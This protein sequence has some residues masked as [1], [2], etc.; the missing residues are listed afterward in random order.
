MRF[1]LYCC[2]AALALVTAKP[3]PGALVNELSDTTK[4]LATRFLDPRADLAPTA[5]T[6]CANSAI[7]QEA[8]ANDLAVGN[9]STNNRAVYYLAADWQRLENSSRS[10]YSDGLLS[11][12]TFSTLLQKGF[13]NYPTD[14]NQAQALTLQ[15][16]SYFYG[17]K[18]VK[19]TDV[20][21][22]IVEIS[23][24][25][26]Q[27][28]K[29]FGISG[30]WW[31]NDLNFFP[32][33]SQKNL[34]TLLFDKDWLYVSGYRYNVG[35]SGDHD[36][37][38]SLTYPSPL[39]LV[40]S[41]MKT[42]GTYD[43]T[44]D[45]PGIYYL[46]AAQAANVPS[47]AFFLNAQP[48][49]LTQYKQA[50]G[51]TLDSASIPAYVTFIEQVLAHWAEEGIRIEYISPINEPDDN[52]QKGSS[53][54]WS[55]PQEGMQVP[56]D[57][58][59]AVFQQLRAA[60]AA[61]S[62][63]GAK[64]VKIM[65]DEASQ[66]TQQALVEYIH[67]Y[68]GLLKSTTNPGWLVNTL[69]G[70]YIDAIAVHM[71]D[72]P[73]DSAI[74]NFKQLVIN[75]SVQATPP[76]TPPPIKMTEVSSFASALGVRKPWGSTGPASLTSEYDPTIDNALDM[77][78]MIWQL[79]TLANAESWDW[80]TAVSTMLGCD[81]TID[82]SCA[83]KYVSGK[84]YNDA[85]IYID[86]NYATNKNYNF[87]ISKRFWVFK[88]FTTYVRPGSVRYDIPN[89]SLPYGTVAMASLGPDKT[90]NTVFINRNAT[91]QTITLKLPGSGG[92]LLGMTQTTA[93]DDW[94]SMTLPSVSNRDT[95]QITLPA[96]SVLS[97]QFSVSGTATPSTAIA[98]RGF[99]RASK[100][101]NPN[102][103]SWEREL[104]ERAVSES[105][106]R[107]SNRIARYQLAS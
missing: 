70:Q 53:S 36:D 9:G 21:L 50:C 6:P 59:S 2:L 80:W 92:K 69:S 83:S 73:D 19:H 44:R 58:R 88:H 87:Y 25:P 54:P 85:L 10:Y 7:W 91:D 95:V 37:S 5:L 71:Y 43:W 28:I 101:N 39:R 97:L 3:D 32:P 15:G 98:S 81:P 1:S 78:R 61:S 103:A 93:D 49:A 40:Q 60:L 18:S 20:C 11:S 34:S 42:D 63:A 13:Q 26:E 105:R 38:T 96:R 23:S 14:F 8:I 107:L 41:F 72:F 47:I 84:G 48:S 64:A 104:E 66:I 102:L 89:E 12:S 22:V 90:W 79:M 86:P 31:P 82:P 99:R 67:S 35:A 77:A 17:E 57:T 56:V 24:A 29:S 65:G 106:S 46:K 52:F 33:A 27:T 76:R 51:T 74:R 4:A 30:A 16:K 94:R 62:S 100:V 45:A 75:A 68:S 55:C